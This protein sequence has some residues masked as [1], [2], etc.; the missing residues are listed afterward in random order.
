ME[1]NSIDWNKI[2]DS[3]LFRLLLGSCNSGYDAYLLPQP[4]DLPMANRREDILITSPRPM[5]KK[6]KLVLI[7]DSAFAEIAFEYFQHDSDYEVVAFCVE[8]QYMKRDS[9][10]GLPVVAFEEVEGITRRQSIVF[11]G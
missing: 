10:F 5:E 4:Y 7:G 11:C 8:R 1:F 6:R 9:L 3:V 2:D